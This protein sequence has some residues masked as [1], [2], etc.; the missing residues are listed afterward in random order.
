MK[1]K[2]K[3]N[4]REVIQKGKSKNVEKEKSGKIVKFLRLFGRLGLNTLTL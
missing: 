2:R 4:G 1:G 3:K